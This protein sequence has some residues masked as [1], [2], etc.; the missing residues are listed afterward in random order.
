MQRS[1]LLAL[2]AAVVLPSQ[3]AADT[4]PRQ[5]GIDVLNYAF[6]FTLS[7]STDVI[8]GRA[9]IDVRFVSADVRAIRFD[10]VSP[11]AQPDGK[12]MRVESV[13]VDGTAAEFAHDRDVLTVTLAPAPAPGARRSVAIRY[14]GAPASGLRIGTTRHGER[15]FF[16][17]NW[18]D[19][20]RHWLPTVDHVAEKAT[21]EF[22]VTAPNHYQVISNGLKVEETD[23]TAA[24]RRTHWKQSVPISPWLYVLGAARFAV[25][26]LAPFRGRPVQTWV[27]PQDRDAGFYDF[28]EPTHHVLEYFSDAIGPFAYEKL[29]NIQSPGIGGGMEA[30]TAILYGQNLVTGQRLD[31]IRNVVIHE[32]AHQWWGDAVTEADWDDVW[33]SEGF[34]TYFTLLFRE[35]AY[36]RDDFLQGLADSRRRVL[37]FNAKAPDYRIVH[38]RLADMSQVTTSQIYQKGAWVLHMLRG[39]VGDDA[40]WSGIRAYYARHL[41]GTATTADFRQAMEDASGRSLESF[42]RQW[43]LRGGVPAISATWHYEAGAVIVDVEQTQ[44]GDPF[45]LDIPVAITVAGAADTRTT[46]E[47]RSRAQRFR[48]ETP[49]EPAAFTLDPD[50]WVLMDA[51]VARR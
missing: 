37:D 50:T 11:S 8:A 31:R 27:L 43:L 6:E 19:K 48:I 38:D 34:A 32:L 7:D 35:H 39:I 29:A 18:P 25:Q 10:L 33:L 23:V 3:S 17:D 42:F 40:F 24:L 1:I 20:A 16:S 5:P 51:R 44:A 41:N 21:C 22:I 12:G 46:L 36:G 14:Q 4:Y 45:S 28:A 9:V 30:A 2:I 13:L 26:H 15:S 47:V 49:T